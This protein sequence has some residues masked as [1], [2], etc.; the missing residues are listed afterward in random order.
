MR[1]HKWRLVCLCGLIAAAGLS[2]GCDDLVR[3]SIRDG[4]YAY[5]SGGISTSFSQN[6]AMSNLLSSMFTGSLFG[7]STNTTTGS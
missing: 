4:M 3:T 1:R 6:G 7:S 2:G 5:I